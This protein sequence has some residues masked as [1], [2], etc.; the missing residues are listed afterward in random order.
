MADLGCLI[1]S[2]VII[3]IFYLSSTIIMLWL[4]YKYLKEVRAEKKASLKYLGLSLFCAQI[5]YTIMIA[6]SNSIWAFA[7]NCVGQTSFRGISEIV[8]NTIFF[9]QYLVMILFSFYR[10][11]VVFDGTEYELS[12]CAIRTFFIMYALAL[13]FI[14]VFAFVNDTDND[15]SLLETA[16]LLLV[17]LLLLS[18]ILLLAILFV[19]KLIDV[20]RRCDGAQQN[21]ANK[22]ISGITKQT[23]LTFTSISSLFMLFTLIFLLNAIATVYVEEFI[24]IILIFSLVDV[25]TNFVCIFLSYEAFDAY[26]TKMCGCCDTKCKQLCSK[27]AKPRTDEA[28]ANEIVRG[29]PEPQQYAKA[30]LEKVES[31][32][33]V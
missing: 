8:A 6:V 15:H 31:I 32:E 11:R 12:K 25:W 21:S 7:E 3:P 22:L 9:A 1:E 28:I 10:L 27:L 29:A 26:Y 30:E 20:N 18:L 14:V 33:T 24:S 5:L 17:S 16:I 2:G 19:K 23:I 13:I 4:T